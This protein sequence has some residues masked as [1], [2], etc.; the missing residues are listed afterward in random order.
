[1]EGRRKG[2]RGTRVGTGLIRMKRS[3]VQARAS[4]CSS[5]PRDEAG[6]QQMFT[7]SIEAEHRTSRTRVELT[8][9]LWLHITRRRVLLCLGN[10]DSQLP[11]VENL[12]DHRVVFDGTDRAHPGDC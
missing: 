12:V 9:V 6:S 4:L 5:K 7:V 1:M 11:V 3:D 8:E 10:D 2:F